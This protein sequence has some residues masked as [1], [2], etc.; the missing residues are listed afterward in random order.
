M[1]LCTVTYL[2]YDGTE[3]NVMTSHGRKKLLTLFTSA[4]LNPES[5]YI[6]NNT[7]HNWG[8]YSDSIN[9][10]FYGDP[11][12]LEVVHRLTTRWHTRKIPASSSG[13]PILK[14]LFIDAMAAYDSVYYG[15]AN[16]DILFTV[17]LLDTLRSLSRYTSNKKGLLVTGQRTNVNFVKYANHS[18]HQASR[19]QT[20]AGKLGCLFVPSALDYFI[21]SRH[22]FPWED[23]PDLVIGSL[24]FDN[25]L[26]AYAITHGY[27]AIDATETILA[28][29]QT[30]QDGNFAGRLRSGQHNIRY[31]DATWRI[32]VS[33]CATYVTH[34]DLKGHIYLT[35]RKQFFQLCKTGLKEDK[36]PEF[37]CDSD[38]NTIMYFQHS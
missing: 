26:L 19:L 23:L 7:L 14:H 34:S 21:S 30:T 38:K 37:R 12:D 20:L 24:G 3:S 15:Y 9:L 8:Q 28:V 4:R 32:G 1:L 22:G 13:L 11:N 10:L 29:H 5:L 18:V 17:G 25:F 27:R 33:L 36:L 31:L 2:Q 35:R 6:Q 16:S